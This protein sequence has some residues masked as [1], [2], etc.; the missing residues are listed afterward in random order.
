MSR[1]SVPYTQMRS[2]QDASFEGVNPDIPEAGYYEMKL[3]SGGAICGIH[4]WHGLPLDPETGE[5]M[6][7]S[8]GWNAK[9]NGRYYLNIER[10][11][12]S[13]AET[14]ITKRK[15]EDHCRRASW[16]K[17]HAPQ[18]ALANPHRKSNPLTS[19]LHF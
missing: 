12:P 11:W 17:E 3:R 6:D 1:S 18:S 15:Y 16:A 9:V 13:C 5:E 19:P 10:I 2:S 7:R 14:K 8:P 4:I